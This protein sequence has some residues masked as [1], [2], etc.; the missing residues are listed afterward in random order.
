MVASAEVC[1]DILE[2]FQ[3]GDLDWTDNTLGMGGAMAVF[4]KRKVV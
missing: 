2:F 1:V 3:P 4:K